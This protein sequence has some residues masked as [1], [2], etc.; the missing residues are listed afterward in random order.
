MNNCF[1]CNEIYCNEKLRSC[2]ECDKKY[3][4]SCFHSECI[5]YRCEYLELRLCK[6]CM[7]VTK[8]TEQTKK[9]DS[10]GENES[11]SKRGILTLKYPIDPS[12]TNWDDMEKM[13]HHK[14]YNEIRIAPKCVNKNKYKFIY[15]TKDECDCS[16]QK[17]SE[18][19]I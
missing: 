6:E 19:T 3:C 17:S 1:I 5:Q 10:H 7:G 2:Y 4:E 16:N 14:F 11:R 13:F 8:K 15:C 18:Y 12:V 9:T